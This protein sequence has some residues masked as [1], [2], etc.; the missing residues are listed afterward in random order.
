MRNGRLMSSAVTSPVGLTALHRCAKNAAHPKTAR[1]APGRLIR[2]ERGKDE[3]RGTGRGEGIEKT[4]VGWRRSTASTGAASVARPGRRRCRRGTGCA[5]IV[6]VEATATLI[7][8]AADARPPLRDG[9]NSE[10]RPSGVR[11]LSGDWAT[12]QN[13]FPSRP[14]L[15]TFAAPHRALPFSG[16]SRRV[17]HADTAH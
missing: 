9:F 16:A 7:A 3:T 8:A 2:S 11:S 13:C 15:A 5:K 4:H 1:Q 12:N 14:G 10:R 6:P 17:T